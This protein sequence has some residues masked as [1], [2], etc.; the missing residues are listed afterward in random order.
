LGN[1]SFTG[2]Q[3]S[4]F[5][6]NVSATNYV[7]QSRSVTLTSNQTL[8][9]IL[10]PVPTTSAFHVTG[11]AT[12]DDGAPVIGATV[13][14][15]L[16]WDIHQPPYPS[17]SAV[18][19]RSGSYSVDFDATHSAPDILPFAHVN[20]DSPGHEH[21]FGYLFPASY[22]EK[23]QNVSKNLHLYRI[24]R[25]TAGE[26]TAVT[27]VP[28]DKTCG[29]GDELTCR[30]VQVVVPT[31]GLLTMSCD[32]RGDDNGGF[33]LTIVGYSDRTSTGAPWHVT[34]GTERAVDIGMWF[35]STV[36]QLCVFKTSLTP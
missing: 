23:N 17:F 8:N 19:N 35:T 18:T 16:D 3:Q 24:R 13:T 2:L 20:A 29:V 28:G 31:D 36:S 7:S 10:S 27:V 15:S 6:V 25:I 21:F 5:T 14:V 33:G 22:S 11:I 30:T 4:G 9:F 1:Y 34:A 32:P 12:D 26:S